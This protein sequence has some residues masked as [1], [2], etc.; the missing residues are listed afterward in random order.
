MCCTLTSRCRMPR[1]CRC[2]RPSSTCRMMAATS[3][4]RRPWRKAKGASPSQNPLACPPPGTS[5]P[6]QHALACAALCSLWAWSCAPLQHQAPLKGHQRCRVV[7]RLGVAGL[8]QRLERAAHAEGHDHPQRVL[9]HERG[10]QRQDV[11]VPRAL[12]DQ[13]LINDQVL[14]P[15][16]HSPRHLK[17]TAAHTCA[18]CVCTSDCMHDRSEMHAGPSDCHTQGQTRHWQCGAREL[19][20]RAPSFSRSTSFT[21]TSSPVCLTTALYTCRQWTKL[22]AMLDIPTLYRL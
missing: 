5:T 17:V 3:T 18:D 1:E 14:E 22:L 13:H 7:A 8:E 11:A 10:V 2:A 12:H 15:M 19:T 4:S 6:N 21:A 16:P 20:M 9:V